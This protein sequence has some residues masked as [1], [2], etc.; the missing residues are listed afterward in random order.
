MAVLLYFPVS[1]MIGMWRSCLMGK[2]RK[3]GTDAL[4]GSPHPSKQAM[5]AMQTPILVFPGKENGQRSGHVGTA[6]EHS[7]AGQT[8]RAAFQT[9]LAAA[10]DP[11]TRRNLERV[12]REC[13]D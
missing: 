1:V 2:D 7:S 12:I 13:A 9:R 8:L 4:Q 11:E 6:A 10:T 5:R 3:V